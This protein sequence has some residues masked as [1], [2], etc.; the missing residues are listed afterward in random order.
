MHAMHASR[1]ERAPSKP[2]TLSHLGRSQYT[3]GAKQPVQLYNRMNLH[4]EAHNATTG[5]CKTGKVAFEEHRPGGRA[6]ATGLLCHQCQDKTWVQQSLR[7]KQ[8]RP[9]LTRP[10][11]NNKHHHHTHIRWPQWQQMQ[12]P[13]CHAMSCGWHSSNPSD[14]V[15]KQQRLEHISH[16]YHTTKCQPQ[17]AWRHAAAACSSGMQKPARI[18]ST[19]HKAISFSRHNVTHC[20]A[21]ASESFFIQTKAPS[22]VLRAGPNSH[23]HWLQTKQTTTH[24]SSPTNATFNSLQVPPETGS[25]HSAPTI[26]C[27]RQAAIS[28]AAI[29]QTTCTLS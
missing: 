23:A 14:A 9:T 12:V 1:A 16:A 7:R 28:E 18:P 26:M 5:L 10:C 11:L 15:A 17:Q 21:T 3:L 24:L 19:R 22:A 6:D 4:A 8:G 20:A 27:R 29:Q 13:K 2:H 25:I